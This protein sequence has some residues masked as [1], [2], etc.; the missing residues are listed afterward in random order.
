MPC[1]YFS[2]VVWLYLHI[3]YVVLYFSL[4]G[5]VCEVKVQWTSWPRYC[6]CRTKWVQ[7]VGQAWLL[8][9]NTFSAL[10]GPVFTEV[11]VQQR[12]PGADV[13]SVGSAIEAQPAVPNNIARWRP[14]WLCGG[15]L[16][17]P[18]GMNVDSLIVPWKQVDP[19][20]VRHYDV[21]GQ[22]VLHPKCERRPVEYLT[23]KPH[24]GTFL[25]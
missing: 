21:T 8:S 15:P 19:W 10:R 4:S 1:S 2:S 24:C 16:V 25:W 6:C 7:S 11:T 5:S 23:L 13:L 20:E 17:R 18:G 14:R 3:L 22:H 12:Q 9:A